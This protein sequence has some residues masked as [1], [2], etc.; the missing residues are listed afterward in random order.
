MCTACV[1]CVHPAFFFRA[2]RKPLS[3]MIRTVYLGRSDLSCNVDALL[4]VHLFICSEQ[5]RNGQCP[6]VLM[7]LTCARI[8]FAGSP[9][10]ALE[11]SPWTLRS[12]NGSISIPTLVPGDAHGALEAAG[13][14]GDV[15]VHTM[16]SSWLF[17]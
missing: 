13:I 1:H 7:Q 10:R 8:A 3:F 5:H 15:C 12:S 14:I 9:S 16:Q 4:N 2:K 6:H 11:Q 17:H